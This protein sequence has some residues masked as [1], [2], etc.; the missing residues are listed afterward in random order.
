MIQCHWNNSNTFEH[1]GSGDFDMLGWEALEAKTLPL[2]PFAGLDAHA[3]RKHLLNAMPEELFSVAS[4]VPITID[5]MRHVLANRT[6][7]PF[8]DLDEIVLQLAREKEIGMLSPEGQ[9][10]ARTL[11]RLRPTDRLA[12]PRQYFLPGTSRRRP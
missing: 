10:R 7:A 5:T 9:V 12:F 3:M 6:A 11:R 8:S 4:E 2:F 1:Y